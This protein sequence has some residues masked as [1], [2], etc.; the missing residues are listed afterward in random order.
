M[1]MDSLFSTSLPTFVSSCLLI[2]G[3]LAGVSIYL[4]VVWFAFP[5]WLVMWSTFS[6]TRWPFVIS[7]L[8]KGL[9]RYFAHLLI[10]VLVHL[11]LSYMSSLYILD[12]TPDQIWF[13]NIFSHSIGCLFILLMVSF[14]VQSFLVWCSPACLFLLLLPL[15][16]GQI[17][18]L[19]AK[20]TVEALT[21]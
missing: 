11:L 18:T 17:Q 2:I 10:G 21:P 8:G 7:S 3:L 4:V 5:W 13:S 20:T 1:H 6:W 9:S 15:L 14:A 16:L 12:I 19:V